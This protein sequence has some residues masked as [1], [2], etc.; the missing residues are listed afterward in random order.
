MTTK[1]FEV[2]YALGTASSVVQHHF[3]M[4]PRTPTEILAKL[5]SSEHHFVKW[6][7]ACNP[8]TLN[9]TLVEL[10]KD[11]SDLIRESALHQ[12]QRRNSSIERLA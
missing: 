8:S 3:A 1:E 10:S 12:L 6:S 4:R 5:A 7:I 11:S 2:Q 9:K